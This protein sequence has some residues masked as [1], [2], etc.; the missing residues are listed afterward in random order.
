MFFRKEG[1]SPSFFNHELTVES[2]LDNIIMEEENE[3][4]ILQIFS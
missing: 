1:F 2:P 4:I 3:N